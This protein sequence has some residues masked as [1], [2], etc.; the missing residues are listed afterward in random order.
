MNVTLLVPNS[1]EIHFEMRFSYATCVE[2]YLYNTNELLS[3]G[4]LQHSVLEQSRC[5]DA[6]CLCLHHHK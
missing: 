5:E 6:H 4:L 2:L 3:I 1:I